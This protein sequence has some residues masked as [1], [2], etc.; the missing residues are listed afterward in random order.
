MHPLSRYVW[1]FGLSTV[2]LCAFA[3]PATA[4]SIEPQSAEP[5][6]KAKSLIENKQADT[7]FRLLAPLE[8]QRAG[9]RNFD[10][11]L[12]VAALESDRLERAA[13][14][15]ERLLVKYPDFDSARLEL[16]RT[17]LRMGSVDLAAQEFTRLL[18]RAPNE[19][20]RKLLED[21]LAEI[22][23]IKERQRFGRSA[24]IEI[25]GGR[26]NNLSSST[27]DFS[28]AI[29]SSFGLPGIVPTGNS[30]H[31]ADKFLAVQTGVEGNYQLREDRSIYAAADL[32]TRHYREFNDY[33]YL[34][35]SAVVGYQARLGQFT[36][37]AS[38][39]V[40]GFRQDGAL[41]DTIG[42]GRV[43]NDRDALGM[44]LETRRSLSATTQI[45]LGTQF[46]ALRYKTNPGQDTN[47]WQISLAL[48]QRP[49]WWPGG[50]L[51][52]SVFYTYDEARR[53][54]NPFTGTSATRHTQG[55]RLTTQ[56]DP[57]ATL[58]WLSSV[59][60]SRRIDDEPFARATL[61]PTGRDDL[62]ELYVKG[63]WKFAG[64]WSLQPYALYARNKSNIDLYTFAKAEGGATLRRDFR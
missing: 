36:Y 30:I 28:G 7:A 53:P 45:V 44:S 35:A 59:G 12:G 17:Y 58:S 14:A 11:W 43:T 63:S 19:A 50:T 42:A 18:T 24:Y 54:L 1:S 20:G 33:D 27:R 46:S 48:Q 3:A 55:V 56:S 39:F 61:V 2:M 21:Y 40:Q 38:A 16:A 34:L 4:Q 62:F 41:V 29:L 57:R 8:D 26:D 52:A 51:Y 37:A 31:R 22:R 49:A 6:A 10:Y 13:L 23:R 64:A 25:G 15:F 5:I 47:Q 32:S 60:W 9:D